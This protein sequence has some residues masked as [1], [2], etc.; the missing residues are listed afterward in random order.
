MLN[1]LTLV[2]HGDDV[3]NK[4]RSTCDIYINILLFLLAVPASSTSHGVDVTVYVFDINQ[5]S[6]PAP[7]HSVLVSISLVIAINF[8]P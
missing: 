5:P 4:G 3:T 1:N 6:L 7:F 8:I 2:K